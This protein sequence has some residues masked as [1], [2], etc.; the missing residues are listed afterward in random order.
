MSVGLGPL[1]PLAAHHQFIVVLR[2]GKMP[3]D[4]RTGMFTAKDGQ[5]AHNPAIWTTYEHAAAVAAQC[6][7]AYGVGFVLTDAD[8]FFCLD[9]DGALQPDGTWSGLSQQVCA[10]LPGTVIE[11]SQSGR[12]LHVWGKRSA[13]PEHAAKNVPLHLE[14]YHRL[15]FI[16]LGSNAVGAMAEDCPALDAVIAGYFPPRLRGDVPDTGPC[17]EWRGPTDDA[18][19]LR[20]AMQSR[21]ARS[22]FGGRASFVDLWKADE[23]VLSTAYPPSGDGTYDASSADAALAQHLAFWTGKDAARIERLMQQSALKRDKW[24]REDYLPRTIGNACGMARDV[25]Q[26]KATEVVPAGAVQDAN[27][28]AERPIFGKLTLPLANALLDRHFKHDEGPRLRCWQGMFYKWDGAAWVELPPADV[29]ASVY[30]FLDREAFDFKPSSARVSD[31]TD[32]LKAAAHLDSSVLPPS[33]IT[34][35]NRPAPGELTACANGLLHLPS[36][37]LH[38]PTPA[39]FSMNAIPSPYINGAPAPVRW[40]A[41]LRDVWPN[42]PDAIGAL[43]ELFGYL[44]TPDTSQQ[45]AFMLIGPKRSGKGTIARVLTDLLGRSNVASPTLSSLGGDFG[46]QPLVGKLVAVV[47]DARVGGRAD[48]K[49]IVENLLRITGED[50]VDVNRK[51]IQAVT[52]RL[53]VRF[54][55]LTNEL[56]R[57]ADSS[58]AMSSRFIILNMTESFFGREDPGLTSKLLDELPGILAWAVEGWT[59]LR[60]R[61]HFAEPASSR[62]ASQDLADLGSPISTFVRECCELDAAA[63]VATQSLFMTWRTWCAANGVDRPGASA[64]FARDLRAAFPELTP[65]RPREGKDRAQS[66][67]GIQLRSGQGWS[68]ITQS[69]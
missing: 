56:P 49:V 30:G 38:L 28:W 37:A 15:R 20:R 41:F 45:K 29:R 18:E 26:D 23:R 51:G 53:G 32:A 11:V 1:H 67:R 22:A 33:W 8:P 63:V 58:G 61:G 57:L 66:Y 50:S 60:A 59:R 2:D 4:Y 36:R 34:G 7:P 55:I 19:L 24:E 44:L 54:L 40:L 39:F 69:P 42:D 65:Y 25:L 68:G 43:Q 3:V 6:G 46:L 47:S 14:L 48:P 10:S 9:I 12:G 5:G 52:L 64:T 13:M 16:L 62:E 17:A 31:V 27:Y 21:S 35:A